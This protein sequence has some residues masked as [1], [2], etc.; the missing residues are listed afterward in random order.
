MLTL[1]DREPCVSFTNS[2]GQCTKEVGGNLPSP[3]NS[4]SRDRRD[5]PDGS[6]L[7]GNL[8]ALEEHKKAS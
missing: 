4:T 5:D 7:S 3:S 8:C 1:H 6:L 2:I